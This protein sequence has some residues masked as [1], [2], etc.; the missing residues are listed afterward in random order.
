MSENA[1]VS[2]GLW[3]DKLP[4]HY[5]APEPQY[6]SV[7]SS[8]ANDSPKISSLYPSLY[9][10]L[11]DANAPNPTEKV[12]YKPNWLKRGPTLQFKNRSPTT[13][14]KLSNEEPIVYSNA[15][16]NYSSGKKSDDDLKTLQ[17]LFEQTADILDRHEQQMPVT[18]RSIEKSTLFCCA[19]GSVVTAPTKK[20]G[21]LRLRRGTLGIMTSLT[22]EW[23]VC[24]LT[25]KSCTEANKHEGYEYDNYVCPSCV[26]ENDD[27][28]TAKAPVATFAPVKEQKVISRTCSPRPSS[29][30]Q[31]RT[32][33]DWSARGLSPQPERIRAI[34]SFKSFAGFKST[35]PKKAPMQF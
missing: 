28:V 35:S 2:S 33:V 30:N 9:H 31:M 25:L 5:A 22:G 34:K 4:I 17:D 14:D 3:T 8:N 15:E 1:Q 10:S 6:P 27:I 32:T 23:R 29:A 26:L 18:P 11:L 20:W 16:S 24:K 13:D 19:H 7:L 12:N 21:D